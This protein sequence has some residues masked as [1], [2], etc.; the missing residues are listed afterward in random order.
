MI[1]DGNLTYPLVNS[2]LQ[3]W[4]PSNQNLNIFFIAILSTVLSYQLAA[5]IFDLFLGLKPAGQTRASDAL[6][7]LLSE[8]S[9]L[10]NL[11]A[12]FRISRRLAY[13]K[14]HGNRRRTNHQCPRHAHC[15]QNEDVKN[16]SHCGPFR[17]VSHSS[18]RSTKAFLKLVILSAAAPSANLLALL[19]TTDVDR[20]L[21][22]NDVSFG[23]LA[24]GLNSNLTGADKPS[25]LAMCSEVAT[26]LSH[27]E[28]S[29]VSF[30][31]CK[32]FI[33]TEAMV[34]VRETAALRLSYGMKSES[35]GIPHEAVLAEFEQGVILDAY[36]IYGSLRDE[37][38]GFWRIKTRTP[39]LSILERVFENAVETLMR[40]CDRDS[41]EVPD[42]ESL[43]YTKEKFGK[44][45][46]F[47]GR[48]NCI[49]SP[50]LVR[51]VIFK[52]I[53]ANFTLVQSDRFKVVSTGK[54]EKEIDA[55]DFV[56]VKRRR[57]FA[58]V[59]VLGIFV[60]VIVVVRMLVGTV[61]SNDLHLGTELLLKDTLRLHRCDSMLQNWSQVNYSG[62]IYEGSAESLG[63][64]SSA[65]AADDK[66]EM[67]AREEK[68]TYAPEMKV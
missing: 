27:F 13:W 63:T 4:Q 67:P 39:D 34:P 57:T 45:W 3:T 21:S 31:L 58:T 9:S 53:F 19:L 42:E 59:G 55:S 66:N 56:F 46:K 30:Y 62:R 38:G 49:Y 24:F 44:A 64:D 7:L 35:M 6:A 37:K 2:S 22:F 18:H 10:F 26:T 12:N 36:Y 25:E 32:G 20:K 48:I 41:D 29:L 23:G 16:K 52:E 68:C 11:L 50:L 47:E 14:F 51:A 8:D 60:A 17:N 65:D 1:R 61:T 43:Q 28:T 54:D 15:P 5:V 33:E 40:F